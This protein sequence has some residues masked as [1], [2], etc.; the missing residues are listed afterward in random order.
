M[1][2]VTAQIAIRF[3]EAATDPGARDDLLARAGVT[4]STER[5]T[6]LRQ[7][8]GVEAYYD[9]LERAAE[10]DDH[11]LPFRYA[12]SVRPEDFG[13]MGLAFKTASTL[14][15]A[16]ERLVRYVLVISDSLT[17]EL[18][19]DGRLVMRGRPRHRRGARL[20]NEGALAAV[21]SLLRQVTDSR[22][23]LV[24][25]TFRHP[26]PRSTREHR[27][28]FGCPVRFGAPDDALRFDARTLASPTRLADEGLSAYLL[29]QLED[30]R[31]RQAEPSLEARVQRAVADGLCDGPPSREAI[32]RRLGMSERTLHRRLAEGGLSFRAVADR[33]RR[34]VAESLLND[35]AHSLAE[36][37]FLTGFS[38]QSAFSRAFK[39]WSGQTPLAFRRGS[40]PPR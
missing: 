14:R 8:V 6:A 38:E 9:L 30:L 31:D 1:R 10:E 3:A 18:A 21:A 33:A 32:A 19:E 23:P 22:V 39:R 27:A 37:A 36:V 4:P 34:E 16:L 5:A 2:G 17:Y 28:F 29:A 20:A 35:A 24:E 26:G 12:A 15:E 40:T 11:A 25:V 13:A 7:S